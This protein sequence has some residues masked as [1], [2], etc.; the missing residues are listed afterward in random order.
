MLPDYAEEII[1]IGITHLTITINTV[2]KALELKP[3]YYPTNYLYYSYY[4]FTGDDYFDIYKIYVCVN[5]TLRVDLKR[6]NAVNNSND[7]WE[8]KLLNSPEHE[9]FKR[10]DYFYEFDDY[11]HSIDYIHNYLT[12]R[13]KEDQYVYFYAGNRI[14][15]DGKY[16]LNVTING[17]GGKQ[18]AENQTETQDK[19]PCTIEEL[20]KEQAEDG[21]DVYVESEVENWSL[22]KIL[23]STEGKEN[24][25]HD[26]AQWVMKETLDGNSWIGDVFR[27][28]SGIPNQY[29][30][31]KP[32]TK[33]F[34]EKVDNIQGTDFE[35]LKQIY[36][37]VTTTITKYENADN[38]HNT[39]EDAIK[40]GIGVCRDRAN[41]LQYSLNKKGINAIIA[42]SKDHVW[43]R[44]KV[45]N[46]DCGTLEFDLDPTWYKEFLPLK[47]RVGVANE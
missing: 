11:S 28:I 47:P 15:K 29:T 18:T 16:A 26:F 10:A 30:I 24:E 39:F 5:C 3:K 27:G 20:Q 25:G 43:I 35:K 17:I 2:D 12:A 7:F 14:S 44:V 41:L 33:K 23:N 38:C 31:D 13:T 4:W 1:N 34:M 36:E 22:E 9:S 45:N 21:I 46:G 37:L 19:E 6:I 42:N 40:T 8:L 32:E